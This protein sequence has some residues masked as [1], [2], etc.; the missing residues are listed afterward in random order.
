LK[1]IWLVATL[2]FILIYPIKINASDETFIDFGLRVGLS[3]P[4]EKFDFESFEVFGDYWFPWSWRTVFDW[5]IGARANGSVGALIQGGDTALLTTLGPV[6][7]ISS[8]SERL[9]FD[10]GVGLALVSKK[11]VGDHR[12]GGLFEFTAHG[13]VNYR[14]PWNVALGYRFYHISDAGIFNGKGLNRHLLELSYR[15]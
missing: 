13:G 5:V 6:M 2:L 12:F 8:P 15:F 14:F 1:A 9:S 3:N 4:G 11:K 10:A 7:S